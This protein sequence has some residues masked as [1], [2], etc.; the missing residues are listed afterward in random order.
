MPANLFGVAQVEL[1][2][3]LL[4][5][6]V[7]EKKVSDS[8]VILEKVATMSCKA[9]VKANMALEQIEVE[10]LMDQLLQLENPF[11]CPHGRPTIIAYTKYDLE[12]LFKRAM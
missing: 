1:L 3:E 12:K 9:A 11:T 4:D 2:T 5:D 8:E 10:S 7:E 6:L